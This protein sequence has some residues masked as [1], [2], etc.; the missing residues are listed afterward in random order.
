MARP[1]CEPCLWVCCQASC[2]DGRGDHRGQRLLGPGPR[3]GFLGQ[4]AV[5]DPLGRTLDDGADLACCDRS[6][7]HIGRAAPRLQVAQT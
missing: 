1:H 4:Q 5:P 3:G 6:S 2:P 7:P